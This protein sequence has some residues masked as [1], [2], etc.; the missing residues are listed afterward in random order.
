MTALVIVIVL[1]VLAA[2]VLLVGVARRRD[3]GDAIGELSRETRRR[4]QA[5][6][7]VSGEAPVTGREV[8][9]AAALERTGKAVVAVG[10]AG[11]PPAPWV[12]PDPEAVSVTRRQFVPSENA[13]TAPPA[14]SVT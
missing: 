4:D 5:T 2:F 10:A 12:A 8:E 6:P 9:K 14:S 11:A 1:G 13:G 3:T 7:A